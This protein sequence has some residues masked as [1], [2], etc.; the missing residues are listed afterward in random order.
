[1]NNSRAGVTLSMPVGV[2]YSLKVAYG[3]GVF[4]RK[5]TNFT[6]VAVAMQALW[7]SPR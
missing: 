7:L 5:G 6:S 2:R 1:M 3:S 4:V